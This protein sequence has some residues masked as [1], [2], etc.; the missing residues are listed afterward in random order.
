M[1]RVTTVGTALPSH[2]YS[3][4]A[5]RDAALR[6]FP[7]GGSIFDHA[8]I[9]RRRFCF[10]LDTYFRER[11]FAS[12]N[13]DYIAQGLPLIDRAL[14]IPP[15]SIHHLFFVTTTGVTTPSLDAHWMNRRPFPRT[16]KRTPLFGVGCAGGAVGLS[17][18]ADYV[19]AHPSERAVAAS[20]ELCGLTFDPRDRS[21]VNLIAAAL[22]ADGAAC[23]VVE[24][25]GPGFEIV[26]TQSLFFPD[27]LDTMG[28][29][30][31]DWGFQLVLSPQLPALM[32]REAAGA[33]DRLLTPHGLGARDIR[34]WIVHPGGPKVMDAF[35][36]AV[37]VKLPYSREF[38]REHGNLSSAS[39]LFILRRALGEARSGDWG[40]V[41]SAGPGFSFE[42]LLLR[43]V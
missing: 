2:V 3:Q 1:P 22:F 31:R 9:D 16:L 35:E 34:H 29:E 43:S 27:T 4:S 20:L 38:L 37:G 26:D 13:D 14:P 32:R 41:M 17:R 39:V 8:G 33:I 7:H 10:E 12:K 23:A 6:L 40:V 19:R 30:F 21:P 18:A 36:E 25:S 28:W 5:L 15:E 24:D 42:L 11:S